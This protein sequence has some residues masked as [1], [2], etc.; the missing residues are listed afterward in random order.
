MDIVQGIISFVQT[1][2][3][4]ILALIGGLDIVLGVV[5]KWTKWDW[6]DSAYAIFHSW[7]AK[8]GAKK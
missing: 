8:L 6:D 7:I 4:E 1:H 2:W 5:V 3:V